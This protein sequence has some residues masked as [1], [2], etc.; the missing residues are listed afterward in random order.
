MVDISES[1]AGKEFKTTTEKQ[2]W[3]KVKKKQLQ[4]AGNIIHVVEG[5][6]LLFCTVIETPNNDCFE[7][8]NPLKSDNCVYVNNIT[9]L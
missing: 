6:V 9:P 5:T 4:P 8:K 3:K 7:N 1:N 2:L